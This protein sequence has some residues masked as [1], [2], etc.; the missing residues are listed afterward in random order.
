[1]NKLKKIYLVSLLL[2]SMFISVLFTQG[3]KAMLTNFTHPTNQTS[4]SAGDDETICNDSEFITQGICNSSVITM[5]QTSG[6]GIFNNSNSLITIYSPGVLDI[7]NG[8]VILSLIIFPMGGSGT[9]AIYDE[10]VLHLG[11]C[12]VAKQL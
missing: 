12:E 2:V 11:N 10:M 1:M 6:D 7:A 3:Q 4:V 9:E 5:W 8:Q